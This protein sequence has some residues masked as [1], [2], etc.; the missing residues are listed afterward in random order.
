MSYCTDT[1]ANAPTPCA[2]G[3]FSN[4]GW[5]ICMPCPAGYQCASAVKTPCA[6]K[7]YAVG[8]NSACV[9]V[10]DGEQFVDFYSA[11]FTCTAGYYSNASTLYVCT[12]CPKGSKCTTT[13]VTAC[14]ATENC[15]AGTASATV[16]P[17]YEW[18]DCANYST[19]ICPDGKYM[20]AAG[21]CA[22]C[23][24]G[25]VCELRGETTMRDVT[26]GPTDYYYS[27]VGVNIEYICP[28]GY[29]CTTSAK[30]LCNTGGLKA[31]YSPEGANTCTRCVKP[32]ACPFATL[33]DNQRIDCTN[34]RGY[35]QDAD[36]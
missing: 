14:A 22:N 6:G 23:P 29:S 7:T 28:A 25:K 9:A 26:Q 4:A 11:P 13:T 20:T 30:T 36:D 3:T 35:Y 1:T 21:A 27:P 32:Y 2:D 12:Q 18:Q 10:V 24:A 31:Y 17:C 8:G 34:V 5:A 19:L 33:G 16:A 15:P